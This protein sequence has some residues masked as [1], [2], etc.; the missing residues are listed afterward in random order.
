MATQCSEAHGYVLVMD[1]SQCGDVYLFIYLC[2]CMFVHHI[3]NGR[4][5][6][7]DAVRRGQVRVVR[8]LRVE[9][10]TEVNQQVSVANIT[11]NQH[12]IAGL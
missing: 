3:Q 12:L 7:D 10:G 6:F 2:V 8:M 1:T 9:P 4:T 5:A 11:I